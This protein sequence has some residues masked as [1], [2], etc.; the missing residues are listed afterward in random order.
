MEA[1]HLHGAPTIDRRLS[2]VVVTG[3]TDHHLVFDK[4]VAARARRVLKAKVK[5]MEKSEETR[6][7]GPAPALLAEHLR[8][9]VIAAPDESRWAPDV[10]QWPRRRCCDPADQPSSASLSSGEGSRV[11]AKSRT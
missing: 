6:C 1:G 2:G 10:C 11:H 3:R 9:S 5:E 8:A 7:R 4:T